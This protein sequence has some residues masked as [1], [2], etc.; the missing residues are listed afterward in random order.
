MEDS[1]ENIKQRAE[2]RKLKLLKSVHGTKFIPAKGFDGQ[3]SRGTGCISKTITTSQGTEVV[4]HTSNWVLR[5]KGGWQ[6][7]G[8]FEQFNKAIR[9][10]DVLKAETRVATYINGRHSETVCTPTN[11]PKGGVV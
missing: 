8:S 3:S 7:G 1:R 9:E 2:E 10:P 5:P 4:T 6:N 11:L